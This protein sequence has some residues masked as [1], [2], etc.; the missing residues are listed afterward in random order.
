MEEPLQHADQQ[1]RRRATKRPA[2]GPVGGASKQKGSNGSGGSPACFTYPNPPQPQPQQHPQQHLRDVD[3]K[4]EGQH[5]RVRG[6]VANGTLTTSGST[7]TL[8]VIDSDEEEA[9]EEHSGG[10]GTARAQPLTTNDA[11]VSPSLPMPLCPPLSSHRHHL[12]L[13]TLLASLSSSS[14]PTSFELPSLII[15]DLDYTLWKGNVSDQLPPFTATNHPDHVHVRGVF[16]SSSWGGGRGGG[17]GRSGPTLFRLFPQ[18]REVSLVLPTVRVWYPL[19]LSLCLTAS[20][21]PL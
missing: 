20:L 17:G 16:S 4:A 2:E 1:R 3:A 15:V 8:I 18:A 19:S 9:D 11:P 13:H 5:N 7:S 12:R 10:E 14:S 6:S 21:L